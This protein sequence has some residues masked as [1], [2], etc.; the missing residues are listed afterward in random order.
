MMVGE[1]DYQDMFYSDDNG[2]VTGPVMGHLLYASFVIV[3]SIVLMNLV[4]GL[5]VKDIQVKGNFSYI[6]ASYQ[7]RNLRKL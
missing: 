3:V 1:I 6:S 5:T 2:A 4:I 7:L